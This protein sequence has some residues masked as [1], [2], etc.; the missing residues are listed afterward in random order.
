MLPPG[1][2]FKLKIH[3]NA[4]AAGAL[5]RTPRRMLIEL[6]GPLA[7]FQG[8]DSRQG[9]EERGEEGRKEEKGRVA[10]CHFFFTI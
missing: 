3:Q 10:F 7:C 5:P 4:Y 8:A 9:G 1:A 6:P 2:I